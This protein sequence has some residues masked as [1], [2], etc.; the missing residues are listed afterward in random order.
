MAAREPR[1]LPEHDEQLTL[2]RDARTFVRELPDDAA[3]RLAS[4]EVEIIF[5]GV[6]AH[7][8]AHYY[9]E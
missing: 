2:L 3:I 4:E 5:L 1:K 9:A 8:H 7:N 6:N